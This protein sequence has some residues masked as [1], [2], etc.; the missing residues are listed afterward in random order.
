MMGTGY[1]LASLNAALQVA[2]YENVDGM[3]GHA[4]CHFLC[5]G[6]TFVIEFAWCLSLHDVGCIVDSLAVTNQV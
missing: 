1:D 2:R 5:L 6:N 3:V 4:G